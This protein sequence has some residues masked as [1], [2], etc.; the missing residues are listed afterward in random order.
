MWC[1]RFRETP[2]QAKDMLERFFSHG[3]LVNNVLLAKLWGC[4]EDGAVGNSAY[5]VGPA[6]WTA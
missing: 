6:P 1:G 5:T 4:W 2:R 3:W